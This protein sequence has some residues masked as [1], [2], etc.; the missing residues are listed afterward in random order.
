MTN[1]SSSIDP[2]IFKALIS[3]SE[4]K[5]EI[6]AYHIQT[7]TPENRRKSKTEIIRYLL[8][9]EGISTTSLQLTELMDQIERDTHSA[10]NSFLTRFILFFDHLSET[11]P[12]TEED[13]IQVYRRL[14]A[15]GDSHE[16][17]RQENLY[18]LHDNAK[19]YRLT[20]PGEIERLM[21][22]L[23]QYLQESHEPEL[24]KAVRTH[25]YIIKV[26]PF[27]KYNKIMAALWQRNILSHYSPFFEYLPIEK[28]IHEDMIGYE[29]ATKQMIVN[30]KRDELMIFL[31]EKLAHSLSEALHFKSLIMTD[32]DRIFHFLTLGKKEFRRKDYMM[33][34]KDISMA[35]AS[36]DL[37]KAVMMG[38]IS[39][40]G[41]KNQ[42]IYRIKI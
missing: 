9:L 21:F 37:R 15:E 2:R 5:G 23:F 3:V 24:L 22:T 29:N 38:C 39:K 19:R 12:Y 28:S 6:N 20:S 25:Q 36:R 26:Q 31:L 14:N 42:A 32:L 34:F 7:E 41:D 8:M 27:K 35:T 11:N 30:K 40:E 1:L 17:Y 18:Y 4:K 16:R 10:E 33:I 13:F